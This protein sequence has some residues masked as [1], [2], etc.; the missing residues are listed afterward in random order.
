MTEKKKKRKKTKK[1]KHKHVTRTKRYGVW[2]S[3]YFI[4]EYYLKVVV[5]TAIACKYYQVANAGGP[6]FAHYNLI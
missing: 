3:F 4:R 5:M 1:T 2:F 6:C